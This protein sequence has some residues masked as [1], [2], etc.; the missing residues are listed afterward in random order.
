MTISQR[1]LNWS[2]NYDLL[3][4]IGIC[5]PHTFTFSVINNNQRRRF[6]PLVR[7]D[8]EFFKGLGS[9]APSVDGFQGPSFTRDWRQAALEARALWQIDRCFSRGWTCDLMLSH[10]ARRKKMETVGKG[11]AGKG[12][13]NYFLL[14]GSDRTAVLTQELH[15][16]I[17]CHRNNIA[18]LIQLVLAR[19][20]DTA[21]KKNPANAILLWFTVFYWKS[22]CKEFICKKSVNQ[23][24]IHRIRFFLISK[25][26]KYK[27]LKCCHRNKLN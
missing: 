23:N 18:Y 4:S 17:H 8:G 26:K 11:K 3:I 15:M 22:S 5:P 21:C 6:R 16:Q 10:C 7:G 13:C 14:D 9:N 24:E 20:R 1:C 2:S 27:K 12:K 19:I 25:N